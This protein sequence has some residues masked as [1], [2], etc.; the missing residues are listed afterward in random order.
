M[1]THIPLLAGGL[2]TLTPFAAATAAATAA[3]AAAFL[4]IATQI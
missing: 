4:V 2:D 1:Y 3:A